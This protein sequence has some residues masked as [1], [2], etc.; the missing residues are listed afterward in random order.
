[1]AYSSYTVQ[2]YTHGTQNMLPAEVIDKDAASASI[3]WITVD[4]HIELTRGRALV[5]QDGTSG[6][7][8]GDIIAS[9]KDGTH[10]RFRKTNTKIQYFDGTNWQD[11]ITGLTAG[12]DYTFS[13]YISLAG[14]YVY[15]S[16][17]DGLYKIATANPASYKSMYVD[18]RN[19]KGFTIIND[20]RMFLW[21]RSDGTPD[22]TAL[23]M[24]KIDPQGT[25]YT[26][27][28]GEVLGTG[29]GVQTTFTATLAQCT[30][31]RFVF[32][33][34]I[35]TNPATVTSLD[36]YS[37]VI[38]GTG[39]TG[40]I[41][42]A[43]GAI[44]LTF[45]TAPAALSQIL[46]SYFYE[47]SN[48]NG[49]TDFRYSTTRLAGEGDII[50]QEYLGEPIQNVLVFEGKYYSIKQT[51]AYE[52]DLTNDDTN[53]TNLV[54]RKDVGI[55]SMRA[56]TSTSKG[57]VY[58]NTANPDKPI[59]SLLQRNPVGDNLEPINITPLFKWEDYNFD[60][61][62]IDTYGENIVVMARSLN[63]DANDKLF[64]VNTGQQYSVD[65]INYGG[66]TVT[67]DA[68]VLYIGDSLSDTTYEVFSG[69]DDLGAQLIDNSWEG[70]AETYSITNLKRHRFLRFSGLIDVDQALQVYESYDNDDYQ[71]V[72][73]IR[74]DQSYVDNTAS[75]AIGT[76]GLGT[77]T[78][79]G[80]Q[81]NTLAYRY[82]CEIRTKTPKFR[83][84]KLKLVSVGVGYLSVEWSTDFDIL[85]FE[86]KLPPKY[87]QKQ[88]VSLDGTTDDLPTFPS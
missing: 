5:G 75:F 29:D 45:T 12:A 4:G 55:P 7:I 52:L 26:T 42:Y 46:A 31:T 68:G 43:T 71:L 77:Q 30:G 57:I 63:A 50:S 85:K 87:R 16:G 82:M 49:L 9:K 27:V 14:S 64:L 74:G 81:N 38:T 35:T 56:A 20:Q 22:K 48:T 62:C 73:T 13:N 58:M 11:I 18:G 72:G 54:Y 1:M 67:K 53:A 28:T 36:N 39:V 61:C 24:S 76:Y 88:F 70:K 86:D 33:I 47:D 3:N 84:R 66:N 15:A 19:H 51:C 2:S 83:S 80:G 59:L 8:F 10:V 60:K 79:G 25:N 41:N 23:Y 40:T 6:G 37:G 17:V 44:S 21:N 78:L 65:T 32:G 34:S 69:F